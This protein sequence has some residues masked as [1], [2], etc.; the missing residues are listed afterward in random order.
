MY[1]FGAQKSIMNWP[2]EQSAKERRKALIASVIAGAF[3][4]EI[5]SKFAHKIIIK[6]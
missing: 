5:N 1:F 2:R 6:H 3:L 4:N